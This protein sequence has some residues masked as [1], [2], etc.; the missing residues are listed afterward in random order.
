MTILSIIRAN[1]GRPVAFT[2]PPPSDNSIDGKYYL[3]PDGL[4]SLLEPVGHPILVST[5]E[6]DNEAQL[7]RIHVPN[8]RTI[9]PD[10][11]EQGLLDY[12]AAIPYRIGQAY[13]LAGNKS[14]AIRWYRKALAMDPSVSAPVAAIRKLDRN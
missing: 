6:S 1:P 14:E 3:Y 9:K 4:V 13:A 12:Y 5:D 2:G 10:S 8:Y 7:A 11:L